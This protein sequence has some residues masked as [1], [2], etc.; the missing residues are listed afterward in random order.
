MSRNMNRS[1]LKL[2]LLLTATLLGF[3]LSQAQDYAFK[4]LGSKGGN[5]VDG[6]NL[7]VG[8][9]ISGTQTIV[10][11]A[12]AYLGLAHSSN[13]TLEIKKAG[14][15]KVSDLEAKMNVNSGG[16]ADKYAQFVISELTSKDGNAS[17]YSKYAKTGS[18]TRDVNKA[19]LM[20]VMPVDDNGVS[21][22]S[23]VLGDSKVTIKWFINDQEAVNNSEIEKYRFV[24][25]DGSPEN[26]GQVIYEEYVTADK[27][28]I[29]LKDNKFKHNKTLLYQVEAISKN[30][31][32]K[33]TTP[34]AMLQKLKSKEAYLI[35]EELK[36]LNSEETAISKLIQAKF[37]EDKGLL[38]NAINMYEEAIALSDIPKY[39]DYYQEFLAYYD[40]GES[41]KK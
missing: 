2:I 25:K 4:V 28:T 27:I 16:L 32:K 31:S 14:T 37:Y 3:S 18:V 40:L 21:K 38:A 36:Q 39:N 24:I 22:T 12:G 19:P 30:S 9:T 23:R 26:I 6:N 17:R 11:S 7:K 35:T 41:N 8:A 5:T 13:K 15:Y 29:D 10:V 20:F 34:E 1:K 33:I